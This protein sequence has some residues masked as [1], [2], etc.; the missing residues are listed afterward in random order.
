LEKLPGF[1]QTQMV[2]RV[3]ETRIAG[4]NFFMVSL[5]LI[6]AGKSAQAGGPRGIARSGAGALIAVSI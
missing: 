5:S 1:R 3:A 4:S 6:V 2:A